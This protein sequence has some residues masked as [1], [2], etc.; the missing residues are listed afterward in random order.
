MPQITQVTLESR[1]GSSQPFV[2]RLLAADGS[3]F[4][5]ILDRNPE[6]SNCYDQHSCLKY[7]LNDLKKDMYHLRRNISRERYLHHLLS[8]IRGIAGNRLF[9][10]SDLQNGENTIVV[11]WFPHLHY[12]CVL[13]D[14]QQ[15][16]K[17]RN[18]K[19]E[20][21]PLLS[22]EKREVCYITIYD[23]S[24]SVSSSLSVTCSRILVTSSCG[25]P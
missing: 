5:C 17:S 12:T 14:R 13:T 19:N 18:K 16:N 9:T 15:R 24:S 8:V 10:V 4:L 23:S 20:N 2:N 3:L 6:I 25:T 11:R 21:L 22:A 7:N 1:V